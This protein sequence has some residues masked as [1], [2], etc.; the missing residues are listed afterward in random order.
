MTKELTPHIEYHPNGNVRIKGQ[1]NSVGQREGIEEVFY[2]NG[3]IRRRTPYVG[4]EKDGIVEE[5]YEDGKIHWRIPFK[6][7]KEDGIVEWFCAN[8]NIIKTT[9]WKD[10]EL[11]EETEN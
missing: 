4:G 11:I 1:R 2:P 8:G 10:G 3:K 6:G 5:F 7:G 9:L